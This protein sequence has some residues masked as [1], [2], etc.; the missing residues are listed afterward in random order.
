MNEQYTDEQLLHTRLFDTTE[1]EDSESEY[2]PVIRRQPEPRVL[3]TY[4][5]EGETI[6]ELDKAEYRFLWRVSYHETLADA[7]AHI[8][9]ALHEA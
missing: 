3:A 2:T 4:E 6:E 8:D 5:Y 1:D 7:Q 9:E